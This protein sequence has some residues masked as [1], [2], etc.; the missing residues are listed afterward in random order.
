MTA[1]SPPRICIIGAGPCGLTAL[2]NILAVGLDDVVCYDE[3]EAIGGN[4][5]FS[6][7]PG[8]TS[9]YESTHLISSLPRSSFED[10]PFPN[11]FPLFPSH[12]QMRAYFDSYAARFNLL[13][14][15]RLGVRVDRVV[16]REDKRWLVRLSGAGDVEQIFD[17]LVV[18]SGHH[19]HPFVP[20]Y[21][22][23]FCG[24]SLHSRDFKRP[25]PFRGK[26]VLVVG[27]GNSACDI[28]CDVA[29]VADRTCISMRRG[30][31][32]VPKL[33]LGRPADAQY[34]RAQHLP[35][36][37]RQ[38][39]MRAMLRLAIGP[40]ARYHLQTPTCGPLEMHPTLNSEIMNALSDGTVLPRVGIERLE[41]AN[42]YFLDGH[43]EP[44]DTIIWATG[45]RPSFP[46]LDSTIIDWD[47]ARPP[48][49]YLK[50]MHPR[51]ANLY[52]IGFFQPIGCIWRLADH[53]ARIA[54]L[55]MAGRLDRPIDIERRLENE[56]R[57]RHWNFDSAPR[58]A[59]EVDYYAFR[60]ELFAELGRARYA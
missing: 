18:C 21:P 36:P 47:P 58:H 40:F 45:F 59:L 31:Y 24:E 16:Q 43:A 11:G 17:N 41:Q 55:Q 3:G 50:M 57:F 46:F 5:V 13:P 26:R 4:W 48:L 30:M 10:H 22:G 44:F 32:I 39:L 29:R 25:E 12:R 27:G 38:V 49:L 42:V 60:R 2:R 8:R 51:F 56:N 14:F 37:L 52:F 54:A 34:Q 15:I 7:E 28:A 23:E 6:E 9:V 35:R 19:R 33:I 53:Q 20:A 1:A